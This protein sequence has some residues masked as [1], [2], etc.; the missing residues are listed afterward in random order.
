[1][2][3]LFSKTAKKIGILPYLHVLKERY[4]PNKYYSNSLLEQ[5]KYID[6]YSQFIN[7]NDLCFD[8]GAHRGHRTN[9]FLKLGAKVVA[10]EPQTDCF[11]YLRFKYGKKINL[12]N[13][14][15]GA[16]SGI[17]EMFINNS[18]SLSTFSEEWK[19][20]AL[21][22][23]FSETKWV[24]KKLIEI[25]TLDF[26]I[27]KYGVPK[28]CKID[29]EA[30]EYEV[31]KGLNQDIE[32]IS[33]E[34]ILPENYEIVKNCISRILKLNSKAE[35]NY[36]VGDNLNLELLNWVGVSNVD[37]LFEEKIFKSSSWGDI[38][39]KMK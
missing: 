4:F 23:R 11:K 37:Y 29:V 25:K 10:I 7:K 39:I 21:H 16:K 32:F 15:L 26:M 5:K 36:S 27:K 22:G 14:G 18:S 1:M 31:L 13:C 35:F 19:S 2:K 24:A 3:K 6:F 28:F 8:V 38:Y 17:Q 12:E 30:Y 34:F 20:E 33:F 9:I